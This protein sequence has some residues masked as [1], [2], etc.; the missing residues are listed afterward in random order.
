MAMPTDTPTRAAKPLKS[1]LWSASLLS[2][3]DNGLRVASV[4]LVSPLIIGALGASNYGLW[5]LVLAWVGWFELLDLGM[6]NT[7][8][9]YF[10][11]AVSAG[12]SERLAGLWKKFRGHYRRV[13]VL[14][15]SLT[16]GA[17]ALMQYGWSGGPTGEAAWLLLLLG[18]GQGGVLL[19]RLYPAL[20]KGHLEYRLLILASS[21]R[22]LLHAGLMFWLYPDRLTLETM[23]AVHLLLLFSEQSVLYFL[24][25]RWVPK[26]KVLPLE[27]KAGREINEFAVKNVVATVAQLFR[28]RIDTQLL[29][30]YVSLQAVSQYAVGIRFPNMMM[31]VSNSLFGGHLMSGFTTAAHRKN[32]ADMLADLMAVLRLSACVGLFC[33][34]GLMILG[35]SF[36][37]QWLGPEFVDAGR[38]L[39]VLV[40]GIS[41]TVMMYPVFSLLPAMNKHGFL[42]LAYLGSAVF[43]FALSWYLVRRMGLT[44]VVWATSVELCLQASVLLPVLIGR[45][46][47]TSALRFFVRSVAQ[48]VCIFALVAGPLSW[49]WAN[50][51]DLETRQGWLGAM[52]GFVC[53]GVAT[54]WWLIL[55][56]TD[57]AFVRSQFGRILR[58]KPAVR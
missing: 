16:W 10:S 31:E 52:A 48:P 32:P 41:L 6:S 30:T 36:I 19:L 11:Q 3:F 49:W 4:L 53:F 2:L 8:A 39:R 40:P 5:T 45:A 15:M 29:A 51:F 46:L 18:T 9:R 54:C 42:A 37:L 26:G 23:T 20:L 58:L 43:N 33:G 34:L 50:R 25:R 21:T 24:A 28:E 1:V 17:V 22:T 27:D 7:A 55:K 12:D 35:P 47:Q 14:T 38:V 57:R 13:A 44:G 56:R